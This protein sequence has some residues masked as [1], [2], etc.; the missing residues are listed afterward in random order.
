MIIAFT[1]GFDERFAVRAMVRRS[2]SKDDEVAVI[3]PSYRLD[4]RGEK[5]LTALNDF[6]TRYI[7]Q[8]G[9]KRYEVDIDDFYQ[10]VSS[11]AEIIR[12]WTARPIVLNLSG[13]M[14][15]LIIEVFTAAV[16]SGIPITIEM[17]TEDG[18]TYTEFKTADIQTYELEPLDV[19][20]LKLLTRSKMTLKIIAD[21]LNVSRPTAWRHVKKLKDLGLVEIQGLEDGERTGRKLVA[22]TTPRS[23]LYLK[24]IGQTV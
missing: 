2:V 14:R 7:N 5:A 22:S 11:M 23:E 18:K 9:V 13:G 10:A 3:V 6:V 17:E 15:L 20:I 19:E 12:S 1:F 16:M 8:E 21:S 4:E 24:L